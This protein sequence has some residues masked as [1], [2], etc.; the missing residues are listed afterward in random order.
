M[1][2]SFQVGKLQN[3]PDILEVMRLIFEYA[4]PE[5]IW[6]KAAVIDFYLTILFFPQ[7]QDQ[8]TAIIERFDVDELCS[9]V[10]ENYVVFTKRVKETA[11][12]ETTSIIV[13][14]LKMIAS[15]VD[16]KVQGKSSRIN[17]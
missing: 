6:R 12:E 5:V 2:T 4:I 3:A 14:K 15:L 10:S 17:I 1:K 13:S 16:T 9:S 7:D 8:D 11:N